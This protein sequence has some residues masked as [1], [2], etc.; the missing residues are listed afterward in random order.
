MNLKTS[1]RA[2]LLSVVGLLALTALNGCH[3]SPNEKS[4]NV[5]SATAQK[6]DA[7]RI[8]Y[9]KGQAL[10]LLRLHGDLEKRLAPQGVRVEWLE[11]PAGPQMLE[12]INAG[13][14]DIGATGD[15]PIIFAQAA[16][17]L[18]V[19][20]ANLPPDLT[21]QDEAILVLKD[22]PIHSVADLRGRRIA[23]QKGSGAHNCLVQ[24]LQKAGLNY[25]DVQPVYLAPP[26]ARPAFQ[27]GK[28]EAWVIWEPYLSVAQKATDARM[29]ASGA[30]VVTAGRFYVT[31][32][33]FAQ[34]NPELIRSA[35]DETA[36]TARW[37]SENPHD[38]AAIL[39]PQIGLDVA[40]A[41]LLQTRTNRRGQKFVGVRPID[42]SLMTAQ[43]TVA[44]IFLSIGLLPKKVNVRD[45]LLT[46]QEYAAINPPALAPSETQ[47]VTQGATRKDAP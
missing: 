29:L 3:H 34:K 2:A 12:A 10:H 24:V 25:K 8:G 1:R 46:P 17:L 32:R 4:A 13:S 33:A 18:L 35:L 47:K 7:L 37:A 43:Q 44:D 28:V 45:G 38:A 42:D 16:G 15:T 31:S 22:S 41:E 40:L 6:T 27:S 14:V 23:V 21:G 11:F 9:Q 39:A 26:D 19:Y 5:T 36:K 20:A 30:G